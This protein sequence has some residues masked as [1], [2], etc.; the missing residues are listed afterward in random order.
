MTERGLDRI[1]EIHFNNHAY[2][3]AFVSFSV[4][5][6]LVWNINPPKAKHSRLTLT[7]SPGH[8]DTNGFKKQ[9]D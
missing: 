8:C 4:N 6:E 2:I 5:F 1:I 7:L 9:I 3:K